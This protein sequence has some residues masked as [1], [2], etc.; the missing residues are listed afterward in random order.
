MTAGAQNRANSSPRYLREVDLVAEVRRELANEN[1]ID[2]LSPM[3]RANI[4]DV[5]GTDDATHRT[6]ALLL[7]ILDEQ[8][9]DPSELQR[10]HPLVDALIALYRDPDAA[11]E[12][13]VQTRL[14]PAIRRLAEQGPAAPDLDVGEQLA[15]HLRQN[16]GQQM[17]IESAP[18]SHQPF[19]PL[20]RAQ[21]A[22]LLVEMMR[23]KN[24]LK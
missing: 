23:A 22:L 2:P 20:G 17:W 16:L 6:Y 9:E 7:H 14:G 12:K 15:V 21:R 1:G 5:T 24:L 13:F 19:G 4:D 3:H 11:P 10:G 18:Y 8:V